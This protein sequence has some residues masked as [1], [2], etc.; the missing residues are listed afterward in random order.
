MQNNHTTI[1]PTNQVVALF[2]DHALSFNL[3]DGATMA[4]LAESLIDMCEWHP[5]TPM[6][7]SLKFGGDQRIVGIHQSTIRTMISNS[8]RYDRQH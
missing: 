2:A 7:V 4:Q 5:G 6:A 1:M 3:P 8:Y